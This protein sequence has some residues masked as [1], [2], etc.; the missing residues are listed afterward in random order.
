M[1]PAPNTASARIMYWMLR[2]MAPDYDEAIWDESDYYCCYADFLWL[3]IDVS[4]VRGINIY[5]VA[6]VSCRCLLTKWASDSS[7]REAE[8]PS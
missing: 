3:I 4:N 7:I 8:T 2:A 1:Q 6:L 5:K